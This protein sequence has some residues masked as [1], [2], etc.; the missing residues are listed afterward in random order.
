M[1]KLNL[2]KLFSQSSFMS[3]D[4]RNIQTLLTSGR[5]ILWNGR[6]HYWGRFCYIF[7]FQRASFGKDGY[8]DYLKKMPST[9][10]KLILN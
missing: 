10:M 1:V 4:L 7:V 6:F 2:K 9:K 3:F 8:C 5:N